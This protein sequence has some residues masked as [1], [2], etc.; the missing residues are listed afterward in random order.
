M[1][2][3]PLTAS[4]AIDFARG[5]PWRLVGGL[6]ILVCF[7]GAQDYSSIQGQSQET[8]PGAQDFARRLSELDRRGE[9]P[10][11]LSNRAAL[12]SFSVEQVESLLDRSNRYIQALA[13]LELGDRKIGRPQSRIQRLFDQ[14]IA[15]PEASRL[16]ARAAWTPEGA[17]FLAAAQYLAAVSGREFV[18]NLLARPEAWLIPRELGPA[19]QQLGSGWISAAIQEAGDDEGRRI[20]VGQMIGSGATPE[21]VEELR[22]VLRSERTSVWGGALRACERLDLAPCWGA[23]ESSLPS[24]SPREQLTARMAA[25]RRQRAKPEQLF[26]A[27]ERVIGQLRGQPPGPLRAELLIELDEFENLASLTGLTV[28][29]GLLR[30]LREVPSTLPTRLPPDPQPDKR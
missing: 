2:H 27:A 26:A 7:A 9:H 13:I 5:I 8:S 4:S 12:K 28:P 14:G 18:P 21:T 15:L 20:A 23:L 29:D 11:V 17:V 25:I 24:H 6:V 19:F 16:D 3:E 22:E 30:S 10:D 1:R